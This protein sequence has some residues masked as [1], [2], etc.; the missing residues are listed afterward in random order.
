MPIL[1]FHERVRSMS[2]SAAKP[3]ADRRLTP[4]MDDSTLA[5]GPEPPVTKLGR[6]I[7]DIRKL[8][9]GFVKDKL[10]NGVAL[11]D[12]EVDH[13]RQIIRFCCKLSEKAKP[14]IDYYSLVRVFRHVL[15]YS[16]LLPDYI[17][18]HIHRLITSWERNEFNLGIGDNELND[19]SA[20]DSGE[21]SE[22]VSDDD[23]D[24]SMDDDSDTRTSVVSKARGSA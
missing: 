17:P 5:R 13:L 10:K 20:S 1:D 12:E 16:T 3:T 9:Q 14:Y 22:V 2:L 18:P 6:S 7:I 23:S 24:V 15:R 11:S 4:S 19:D 8:L 21:E